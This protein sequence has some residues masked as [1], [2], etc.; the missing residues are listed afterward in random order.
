[1][2]HYH[3]K[4]VQL[5]SLTIVNY[6][7][8]RLKKRLKIN[9]IF[10]ASL[11]FLDRHTVDT[12]EIK[13]LGKRFRKLDLD[14]SGALSIDGK[15]LFKWIPCQNFISKSVCLSKN[16]LT[17]FPSQNSCPCLNCN[18]IRWCR[19][20]STFSI[21]IRTV[22]SI[23]KVNSCDCLVFYLCSSNWLSNG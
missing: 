5:V 17:F 8:R 9:F 6:N 12:D 10:L 7:W 11:P 14:N 18:R 20:W 15:T 1:M 3:L 21:P 19:E 16:F 4:C 22:K 13:R 2:Y 23:L